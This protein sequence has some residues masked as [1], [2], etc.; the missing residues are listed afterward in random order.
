MVSNSPFTWFII[1]L[2]SRQSVSLSALA[3]LAILNQARKALYTASLLDARKPI[4]NDFSTL[5]PS[6]DTCTI[7]T[8]TSQQLEDPLTYAYHI[9]ALSGD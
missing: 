2:E 8:P 5:M 3:C 4:L 7:P 9:G 6:S 1:S